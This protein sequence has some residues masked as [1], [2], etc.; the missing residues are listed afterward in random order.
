MIH[1]KQCEKMVEDEDGYVVMGEYFCEDCA[2]SRSTLKKC[3][4]MAVK[5]ALNTRKSMGHFGTDGLTGLQKEIY[6]FI[7][8]MNGANMKQLIEKFNISK[9]EIDRQLAV[10]R[11]CE[12]GKGQKRDDG[13]YFVV[14][15]TENTN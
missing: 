14:W 11:H 6:S 9:E 1:C 7:Q 8:E 15:E 13:V 2:I 10:L 5:S 12:L 4:P 3:D